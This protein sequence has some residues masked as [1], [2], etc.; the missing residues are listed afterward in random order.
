MARVKPVA[1]LIMAWLIP[2]PTLDRA[3]ASISSRLT[4]LSEVMSPK[5]VRE[6][7]EHGGDRNHAFEQFITA[8]HGVE[9]FVG[10]GF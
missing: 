8:S 1:V 5:T 7:S 3:E 4:E 9:F 2:P 10:G 6:Q